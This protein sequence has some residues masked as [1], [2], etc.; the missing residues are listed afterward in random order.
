MLSNLSSVKLHLGVA[1]T[2]QDSVLTQWLAEADQ[3]IKTECDLLLEQPPQPIL[4][5]VRGNGQQVVPLRQ[6]PVQQVIEA[7][8]DNSDG[9]YGST[10]GGFG[11]GALL[12]AGQDYA[13]VADHP[14]GYGWSGS[15][16]LARLNGVW[17]RCPVRYPGRLNVAQ[18]RGQGNLRVLYVCGYPPNLIT[19]ATPAGAGSGY[20]VGD[21]IT[22]AAGTFTLPAVV[23][24]LSVDANG[25]VTSALVT[26]AGSYS[27][28]PS[29]P[30]AQAATSGR[31]S[32]A[33][34]TVTSA[35]GVPKDLELLTNECV[36]QIRARKN[37]GWAIN[38]ESRNSY[39]YSLATIGQ[40][41]QLAT[42][43]AVLARYRRISI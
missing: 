34:F 32:G 42:S 24:V 9:N 20:A 7:R 23:T 38:S 1:D 29:S 3:A 18:E 6:T 21:T 40:F 14:A 15:G 16:L 22:L 30:A 4:E 11:T 39:S 12:V 25:G 43:Q 13:L 33:T 28:V 2:S 37:T 5:F 35:G 27:V 41:L 31:G 10:A 36:V 8:L 19:S 17:D 26:A